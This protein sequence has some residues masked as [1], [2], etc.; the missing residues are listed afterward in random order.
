MSTTRILAAC[1]LLA[2][3][4]L[5]QTVYNATPDWI[6]S[7][8]PV[9]TGGALVDINNDGHV[10]WVVA[11]GN[12]MAQEELTVYYNTGSG[13]PAVPDWQST[14][15]EYNGHLDVADVNGDGWVDVAVAV[16]GNGSVLGPAAKLY[17]NNAGTL[18]STPDWISTE[19]APAFGCAFGDVNNDG[20]PDL[21]VATGWAYG[22]SHR[23]ENYVYMNVGGTLESSASWVSDDTWDYQGVLWV[24]ADDDGWLDLVGVPAKTYTRIYQNL[25]GTLETTASWATAAGTGQDAIMAAA[26]DVTGD[27]IRDLFVTNN[28][29]LGSNGNTR[30]YT[31]ISPGMFETT[32][33]WLYNQRYGSAVALAD[34]NDDGLLDITMGAWWNSVRV[35]FN[36]GS[37]F[38]EDP[39]YASGRTSVIEKIALADIDED[40][41][42]GD[43]ETFAANGRRLFYLSRQPVQE[44][45]M[46][47]VDG[48]ELTPDQYTC[49]REFAWIAIGPTPST[50][51][52]VQYTYSKRIDM[53]ITNW[54]NDV[55][56]FVYYNQLGCVGDL[57]GD[58]ATSLA[59]LQAL[60]T[61]YGCTTGCTYDLDHDG[62][63][64]L[65]D[66]QML[67]ADYGCN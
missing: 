7:D 8:T 5:A 10:D 47:S 48:V 31:G 61:D 11:N 12:D 13:F 38:A 21:A 37:G 64:N 42:Y 4:A 59:D 55:G 1:W 28:A 62:V 17:L 20:R 2:A 57:D 3:G 27:G 18:S 50:D 52:Q 54:D 66:L 19:T 34:L 49:S 24:D 14:D 58:G 60:L 67:L 6:S 43:T 40:A 65:T 46:V 35:F 51:V 44:I 45:V 33:G 36:Q 41:L 56:N 29:Q 22:L 23:Y 63:V 32:I 16:L 39:D 30:Q 25:S 9:S 26:G 15:Q 53:A